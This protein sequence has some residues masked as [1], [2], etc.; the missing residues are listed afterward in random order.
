LVNL[1]VPVVPL[2]EAFHEFVMDEPDGRVVLTV[3]WLID[4]E[5]AVTVNVA[6]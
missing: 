1:T 5:P 6:L 2:S 3:Q 4:E